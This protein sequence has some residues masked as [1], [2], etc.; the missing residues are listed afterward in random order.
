MKNFVLALI[1]VL[2]SA[3]TVEAA[4]CGGG[5]RARVMRAPLR[6]VIKRPHVLQY[7][8]RGS[9]SNGKCSR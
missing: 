7:R 3:V 1:C 2:C 5:A 8:L 4:C 6:K 9:C